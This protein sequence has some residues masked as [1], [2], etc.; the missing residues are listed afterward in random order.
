LG[1]LSA[2]YD[3][4]NIKDAN[5][6][7]NQPH[8]F[9]DVLDDP[10]IDSVAIATPA[11]THYEIAKECLIAGK[12]IFVEK[13]LALKVDEAEELVELAD[14]TNR[15]L[16]VGHLLLYHNGI[17]EIKKI[18]QHQAFG[19]VLYCYSNRLNIGTLRTEENILWSFAP[20]DISVLLHLLEEEPEEVTA[21]AGAYITPG[22]PDVTVSHLK[23]NSGISAHIY[24]SW[25]HP[26]KE[27]RLVIVGSKQMVVFSDPILEVYNHKIDTSG[28]VPVVKKALRPTGIRYTQSE[29]LR[30]ELEHFLECV[31][32]RTQPLTD[33]YEALSVLKVLD[34][35]QKSMDNDCATHIETPCRFASERSNFFAHPTAIIDEP[36]SI[37]NSTK[38]WHNTHI[39]Q[40]ATIGKDCILGQNCYIGSAAKIGN[41]VKIQNNVSVYD[42]VEL[43]DNVF[44]GPSVVF[45]NICN[46]RSMFPRKEQYIPTIVEEGAT[47]G[48]N[49]TIVCGSLIGKNAF[50]AAGAVITKPVRDNEMV[51]GN[52]AI[53]IGW[54][55]EC[56][57]RL[58]SVACLDY[59]CPACNRTYKAVAN[60]ITLRTSSSQ[61]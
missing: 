46:P 61:S 56:G 53:S 31:R 4:R 1:E 32:T 42:G 15:I 57:Q 27:Q 41:N 54:T 59:K 35:C 33:G 16:M 19:G 34:A 12:H 51:A 40:G 26:F 37:G 36:C 49:S 48:A 5:G 22:V 44:I 30:A 6:V 3:I 20:H 23:F 18:I 7:V 28:P 9:V 25:L 52:P 13:P 39:M 60:G 17:K 24:V 45:T 55:C 14:S 11:A 21:E 58:Q 2:I 50:V 8:K 38:I 47:I 43:K 10:E 29:P